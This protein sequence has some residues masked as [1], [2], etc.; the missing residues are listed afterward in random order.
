MRGRTGLETCGVGPDSRRAS[1]VLTSGSYPDPAGVALALAY[2]KTLSDPEPTRERPIVG[3]VTT[4]EVL[5][6]SL[7][8]SC[9]RT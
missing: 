5:K 4:T 2:N 9:C 7:T 1:R 8:C 6:S 3:G